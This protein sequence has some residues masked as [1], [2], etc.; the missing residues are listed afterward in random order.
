MECFIKRKNVGR[1]NCVV[2]MSL[3]NK[4]LIVPAD[5]EATEVQTADLT[6]WQ[7]L[8]L[9]ANED[10]RGFLFPDVVNIES[11]IEDTVYVQNPITDIK[12]RDG[13]YM[14]TALHSVDLCT[15]KNMRTQ[16]GKGRRIIFFDI[17]GNCIGT[18]KSNGK[19]TGLSLSLL[20]VEKMRINDGT[21]PTYSPVYIVLK[22]NKELDDR[23]WIVDGAFVN[24]LIPLTD[25]E[26]T[27]VGAITAASFVVDVKAICDGTGITGLVAADFVLVDAAGAAQTKTATPV[28]NIPGR[29]TIAKTVADFV[30]GTI[31]LAA[32]DALTVVGYEAGDP[33]AVNVP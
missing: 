15:H 1:S 16:S 25:V 29:Y 26:I 14:W 18:E 10:D 22:D 2:N 23:G 6:F 27:I 3:V 31:D 19:F 17:E 32:P 9:A 12:V 4:Y 13:K 11:K 20:N 5:F 33:V 8:L 7:D 28:S 24:E 21:N 30:D